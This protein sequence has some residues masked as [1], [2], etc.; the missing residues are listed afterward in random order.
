MYKLPMIVDLFGSL[1]RS[2]IQQR[3]SNSGRIAIRDCR[4][5]TRA[6]APSMRETL[7]TRVD[8]PNIIFDFIIEF[9]HAASIKVNEKGAK[10]FVRERKRECLLYVSRRA[11]E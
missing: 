3:L 6:F 11:R 2:I 8:A 9:P 10:R 5:T 1:S 4:Y 7:C